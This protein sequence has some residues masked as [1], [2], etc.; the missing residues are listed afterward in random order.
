MKNL[1]RR[2]APP[3]LLVLVDLYDSAEPILAKITGKQDRLAVQRFRRPAKRRGVY[4]APSLLWGEAL[5]E[6][7]GKVREP[8][9]DKELVVFSIGSVII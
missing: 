3:L 2:I 5:N 1:L 8:L 7:G 9:V 4:P 6:E